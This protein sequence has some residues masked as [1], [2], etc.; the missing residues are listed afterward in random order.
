MKKFRYIWLVLIGITVFIFAE[1]NY[2]V[3][4]RG[5][6]ENGR[7][8]RVE[9]N[10]VCRELERGTD[11]ISLESYPRIK[12][13][14]SLPQ[15]V[16][17]EQQQ[18]FFQGE[19]NDY[20]IRRV[21]GTYYRIE[22]GAELEVTER[23]LIIIMNLALGIMAFIMF[24]ITAYISHNLVHPF[25]K[26]R[27]IPYEL[28]KG[29][30]TV[31]LKENKNR[32]FGKFIWG[33]DLLRENLEENKKKELEFQQEKQTLILSI[34][35]DIKT[36]LSAIKLYAGALTR[37]LYHSEEKQKE[38]A[39]NIN[40]KADEIESFVSEIIKASQEDFLNLEVE[41]GEFYLEELISEVKAYYEEKLELL[42][43]PFSCKAGENCLLKGDLDRAVELF[44][45]I[46]ENAIKYGDGGYIHIEII[47]EEDCRLLIVKNSGCHLKPEEL[48]HV[49]DSFWRG[50]NTD[51]HPGS[52]LGLYI[53]RQL[54]QKMGGEIY[55]RMEKGEMQ[56]TVVFCRV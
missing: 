24:S 23:N 55:A 36:P 19:G 32:F 34:S 26:I 47:E 46:M 1:A 49:F 53:C 31:G 4:N 8:Y 16:T 14:V 17:E 22:Y 30:L 41:K 2:L 27:E 44:Q 54:I 25:H 10:R 56:V 38:I 20:V 37:N 21:N 35:H 3:L 48:P 18:A 39:E 15:N 29:N 9:I 5:Q 51:K 12:N 33:L 52:G 11:S 42:R 13:I 45:N 50:S 43:I 6:E 28:S 40:K 7:L